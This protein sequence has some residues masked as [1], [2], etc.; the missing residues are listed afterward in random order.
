MGEE[1]AVAPA[2]WTSSNEAFCHF[3][4]ERLGVQPPEA[5]DC[6]PI[7]GPEADV[8]V[9]TKAGEAVGYLVARVVRRPA[10]AFTAPYAYLLVDR[11]AVVPGKLLG[12]RLASGATAGASGRVNRPRRRT[13]SSARWPRA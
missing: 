9:A 13:R 4:P 2:G 8:L 5:Q 1:V 7:A 3:T 10:H 6:D 11:L 12:V